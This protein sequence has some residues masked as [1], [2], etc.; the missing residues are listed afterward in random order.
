LNLPQHRRGAASARVELK[1]V[2]QKFDLLTDF[3]V[4]SAT[5]FI[6]ACRAIDRLRRLTAAEC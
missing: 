6:V 5:E 4:D 2:A 1:H 3:G